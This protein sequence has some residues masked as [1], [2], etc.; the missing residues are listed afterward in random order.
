MC[1]SLGADFFKMRL[2]I[3]TLGS[4]ECEVEIQPDDSI[5]TLKKKVEEKLPRMTA[6]KQ[7]LV[8]AGKV[9]E[10]RLL[11]KNYPA[12]KENER[13]VVLVSKVRTV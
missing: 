7:K 10:D 3:R 5:L 4:E 2:R 11:V 9:L 8:H 1:A 12:L 6:Q 13:L